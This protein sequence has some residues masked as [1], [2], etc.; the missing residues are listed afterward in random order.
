MKKAFIGMAA[1]AAAVAT[2]L[3]SPAAA[4]ADG[5]VD[6]YRLYN[7]N[8][9]EHFY[10]ASAGE[11]AN[12]KAAGWRSE[13]TGW[14]AP[15]SG[16][17]VYRLYNPNG[18]DHHYTTSS[19][20]RDLLVKAGWSNEGVGWQSG[21][22]VAVYRLY[23]PSAATGA[24][25]Y[26]TSA[27]ERDLL[28]AAGWS[29][30]GV[31]WQ[32]V[33]VGKSEPAE[34]VYKVRFDLIALWGN[35]CWV[36]HGNKNWGMTTQYAGYTIATQMKELKDLNPDISIVLLPWPRGDVYQASIPGTNVKLGY[37]GSSDGIGTL[38]WIEGPLGELVDGIGA[39]NMTVAELASHLQSYNG[40]IDYTGKID[41][42]VKKCGLC[43][44][45]EYANS[46]SAG[47]YFADGVRDYQSYAA[48]RFL[49]FDN[50]DAN[51][52]VN[53]NTMAYLTYNG[54]H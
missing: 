31:G 34:K 54:M 48:A 11:R 28:V 41:K 23:N 38:S 5:G 7:P 6:M 4:L 39:E 33:A 19:G 47:I 3:L 30:E 45:H 46:G 52:T 49:S 22:S 14:E 53:A 15:T 10:T 43:V 9:G 8:S 18:G 2:A 42:Y 21:G 17:A 35:S 26:T 32:A 27:G 1:V 36:D 13:G 12:L 20:E 37:Y 51:Y 44:V 24:H 40:A 50:L 25:H 16:T 29:N